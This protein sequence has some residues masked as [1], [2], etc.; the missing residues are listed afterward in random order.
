MKSRLKRV[1]ENQAHFLPAMVGF[2]SWI[3]VYISHVGAIERE[4]LHGGS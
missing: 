2:P 4:N 3:Q 1:Y